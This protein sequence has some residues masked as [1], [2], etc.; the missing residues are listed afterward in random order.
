MLIT[1]S[2]F[3]EFSQDL[4]FH[5]N[6]KLVLHTFGIL[7]ELVLILGDVNFCVVL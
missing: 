2:D 6:Y 7:T 1:F 5:I 3:L 4:F